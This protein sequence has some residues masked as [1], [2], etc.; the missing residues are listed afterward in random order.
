[1]RTMQQYNS[2]HAGPRDGPASRHAGRGRAV[3]RARRAPPSD[4]LQRQRG[5]IR[6][7]CLRPLHLIVRRYPAYH[8]TVRPQWHASSEKNR[9]HGLHRPPGHSKLRSEEHMP[10]MCPTERW[11][12]SI[13]RRVS[14]VSSTSPA[15]ATWHSCHSHI[16]A[17]IHG[18]QAPCS[19]K[20]SVHK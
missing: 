17:S 19:S 9:I 11:K 16:G 1:M 15:L 13:K 2:Q 4:V 18:L 20:V 10:Y 8:M 12:S 3:H 7:K 5:Q 14:R 6:K